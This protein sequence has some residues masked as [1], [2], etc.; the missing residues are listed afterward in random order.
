[1]E[2]DNGSRE[3][4]AMAI[5]Q[6]LGEAPATAAA[7]AVVDAGDRMA[8]DAAAAAAHGAV[9]PGVPPA[10]TVQFMWGTQTFQRSEDVQGG[11][12]VYRARGTVDGKPGLT[13]SYGEHGGG[14][15]ELGSNSGGCLYRIHTDAMSPGAF[16]GRQ[17]W[18]RVY[19]GTIYVT[20]MQSAP[21]DSGGWIDPA[22]LAFD[23]EW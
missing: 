1:M 7:A 16:I 4:V 15:W 14:A 12:P 2:V 21:T 5:S 11:R 17:P 13:L 6:D 18:E 19:G 22:L 20:V 3:D 8:E 10:V 9:Q 23:K